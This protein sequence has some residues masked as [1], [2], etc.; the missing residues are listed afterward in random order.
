MRFHGAMTALATPFKNGKVDE[1]TL[2]KLVRDQ[3]KAGIDADRYLLARF[4]T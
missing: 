3:I 1:K 4:K 2:A